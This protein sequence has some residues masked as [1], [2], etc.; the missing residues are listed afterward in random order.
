MRRGSIFQVVINFGQLPDS[1]KFDYDG[2]VVFF[3]AFMDGRIL[4]FYSD[5]F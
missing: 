5:I 1:K 3:L 4:D 2:F